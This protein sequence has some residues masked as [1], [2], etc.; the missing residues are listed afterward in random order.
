[1]DSLQ[2]RIASSPASQALPFPFSE[3]GDVF[4]FYGHRDH[5]PCLLHISVEERRQLRRLLH[6]PPPLRPSLPQYPK[7][8]LPQHASAP[9][10]SV[11]R[12]PARCHRRLM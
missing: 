9:S 4:V 3:N 5:R 7:S 6:R 10:Q 12:G 8:S 2:E 1:M 11:S